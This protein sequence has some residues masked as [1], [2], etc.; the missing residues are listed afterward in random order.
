MKKIGIIIFMVLALMGGCKTKTKTQNLDYE[1]TISDTPVQNQDWI[2][3]GLS[4]GTKWKCQNEHGL[5]D[6]NQAESDFGSTLP[7]QEQWEE[8]ENTCQWIW[9]GNG[10]QITGPSGKSIVL[11]AEG[12]RN[13][14]GDTNCIGT[15]GIYWAALPLNSE[16]PCYFFS[17]SSGIGVYK[18]DRCYGL[19]VRLVQ[20]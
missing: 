3:L 4:S 9:L 12:Y 6:F 19:S 11:P 1:T 13:C 18:F 7:T 15:Y 8:L 17:N 5:V 20:K 14:D 2:D 10:Y 16:F